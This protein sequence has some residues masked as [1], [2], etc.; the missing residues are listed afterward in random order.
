MYIS[1]NFKQRVLIARILDAFFFE[2]RNIKRCHKKAHELFNK[3]ILGVEYDTYLTY[4]DKDK[5]D[6]T[7]VSIPY[8]LYKALRHMATIAAALERS[9][10]PR[11]QRKVFRAEDVERIR[12]I[13]RPEIDR[14]EIPLRKLAAAEK[15]TPAYGSPATAR[16]G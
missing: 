9:E 3:F 6:L 12:P 5:Y 13:T 7:G 10:P 2:P 8:H 11:Q 15:G 14:A 16:N 1:D 4:L